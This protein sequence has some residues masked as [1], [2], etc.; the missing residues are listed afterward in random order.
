MLFVDLQSS[1]P[2]FEHLIMIGLTA[3]NLI[4]AF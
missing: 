3:K 2:D 4:F 1:Y